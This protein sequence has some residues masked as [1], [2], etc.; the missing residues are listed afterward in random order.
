MKSNSK[1]LI[2]IAI[3]ILLLI[4]SGCQSQKSSVSNIYDSKINSIY[5]FLKEYKS[6]GEINQYNPDDMISYIE[7]SVDCEFAQAEGSGRA[8]YVFDVDEHLSF[9]IADIP[10]TSCTFIID[11]NEY[12]SFDL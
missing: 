10:Y 12:S 7:K 11:G 2:A 3:L 5:E 4:C 8:I 1:K 9:T 6:S